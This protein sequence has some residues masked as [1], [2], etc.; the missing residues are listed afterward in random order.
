MRTSIE[1]RVAALEAQAD[2]GTGSLPVVFLDDGQSRE[3]GLA[4]AGYCADT[5]DVICVKFVASIPHGKDRAWQ[6]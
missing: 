3:D 6:A 2:P 1:N 5:D 4:R